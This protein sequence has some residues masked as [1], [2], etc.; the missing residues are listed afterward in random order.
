MSEQ[1]KQ[2][3][4]GAYKAVFVLAIFM[5]FFTFLMG[6]ATQSKSMFGVLVWGYT[7]WMMY[8]RNNAGLVSMYK[9]LMWITAIASVVVTFLIFQEESNYFDSKL[10][11]M[12]LFAITLFIDY[13]LLVFFKKQIITL[14]KQKVSIENDSSQA[15]DYSEKLWAQAFEEI[16]SESKNSGLWAKCF[17]ETNGDE[18]KTKALYLQKRVGQLRMD[19][20][21]KFEFTELPST[22][23]LTSTI[24]NKKSIILNKLEISGLSV[25]SLVVLVAIIFGIVI[26]VFENPKEPNFYGNNKSSYEVRRDFLIKKIEKGEIKP[27]Y[28]SVV[29]LK[30]FFDIFDKSTA[31]V[32]ISDEEVKEIEQNNT[33]WVEKNVLYVRVFNPHH[34][35]LSEILFKV[36]EG[37]CAEPKKEQEVYLNLRF[38]EYLQSNKS[39]VYM[40]SLPFS[41]REK[42]GRGLSCGDVVMAR[43]VY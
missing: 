21:S 30:N 13:G 35:S 12:M 41:Y 26:A 5:L 31:G 2:P 25:L 29:V 40:A 10:E 34:S 37:R 16:N 14:P 9:V 32:L 36:S 23:K 17:S 27:V 33:W 28:S 38:S 3:M 24:D 15:N 4:S 19:N 1:I 18:N 42:F 43:A 39:S 7:I 20:N 11:I 6:A 22:Q 8:K